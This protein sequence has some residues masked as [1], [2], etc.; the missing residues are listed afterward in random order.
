MR[1][2]D[3]WCGAGV[4]CPPYE[5]SR[6]AGSSCG[7]AKALL[8]HAH[9]FACG[10]LMVDTRSLSSGKRS[11]DPVVPASRLP[12]SCNCYQ[13]SSAR[14]ASIPPRRPCRPTPASSSTTARVAASG[15]SL[16]PAIAVCSVH[17]ARCR[18]RRSSRTGSAIEAASVALMACEQFSEGGWRTLGAR[19]LLPHF[20]L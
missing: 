11:R 14:R 7:W 6:L 19:R 16:N 20:A 15:S 3:G 1:Y 10:A 12:A 5:P 13:L 4:I 9:H 18:A 17:S 2:A 8:R